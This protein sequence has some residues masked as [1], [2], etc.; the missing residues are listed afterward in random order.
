MST[1]DSTS[2][3]DVVITDFKDESGG[4]LKMNKESVKSLWKDSMKQEINS[5]DSL[6]TSIPH[7]YIEFIPKDYKFIPVRFVFDVK[8]NQRRKARL[9]ALGHLTNLSTSKI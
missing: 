4:V 1:L 6:Q 8:Y 5:I 3:K 9:V 2:I 7:I